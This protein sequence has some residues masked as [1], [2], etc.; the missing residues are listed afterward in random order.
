M[1]KLDT[2][3]QRASLWAGL[4][5]QLMDGWPPSTA[6]VVSAWKQRRTRDRS[7]WVLGH[8]GARA[9]AAENTVSAFKRAIALGAHGVEL[10]VRLAADGIPV[11]IHDSTLARTTREDGAVADLRSDVLAG[12]AAGDAAHALLGD[13]SIPRLSEAFAAL[14]RGAVCN[15][16]LKSTA[17]TG[18]R[19]ENAVL[20]AMSA[21]RGRLRFIVSSFDPRALWRARALDPSVRLGYLVQNTWAGVAGFGLLAKRYGLHAIHPADALVDRAMVGLAHLAGLRVHVWTVNDPVRARQLARWG[22]DAVITDDVATVGPAFLEAHRG[23]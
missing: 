15:V 13:V 7:P 12:I 23:A 16:E 5:G 1:S 14:P 20:R 3:A 19:H 18:R 10:D 9:E 11:V 21:H 2:Y 4:G 6:G 8:R 22:V 17:H